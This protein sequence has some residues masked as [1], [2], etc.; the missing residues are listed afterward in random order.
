[1]SEPTDN[2]DDQQPSA[3]PSEPFDPYRFGAPSQHVPPEYAPP[4][5]ETTGYHPP[6]SQAPPETHG[7]PPAGA[8]YPPPGYPTPGYPPP[9]GQPGSPYGQP[10]GPPYGQPGGPPYGQPMPGQAGQYPPPPQYYG[11]QQPGSGSNGKATA[12]LIFGILSI[13][14]SIFTLF[15]A[16]M[17]IPGFIFSFAGL[18]EAKRRGL[19]RGVAKWGIGLTAAG[20]V[21]VLGLLIAAVVVFEKTDCSVSHPSGSWDQRVC[22]SKNR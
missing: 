3:G 15:D 4:G 13:V 8:G 19:G 9:Y 11:Y 5:F 10:G 6:A 16:L 20:T 12:G 1:M 17:I 7:Q 21:L 18:S 14:L 2:A 22:S